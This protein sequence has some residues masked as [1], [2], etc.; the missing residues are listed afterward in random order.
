VRKTIAYLGLV[1]LLF[2]GLC[3]AVADAAKDKDTKKE[4]AS[5][6][7]KAYGKT[8]D[9]VAVEEY[10]LTNGSGARAKI[11]TYGALLTELDVPDRDG[12]L[13]DVVLGFDNLKDYLAGHPYFG[14]TVG[15][16]G[17]RIAGAE[18]TLG[19]KKYKLAA[20]NGRHSLHGGQKGFDKVVWKA[21]P[22]SAADGASV[23]FT[24][25]SK[26]GEEGY[27][28]N[29]NVTVIY[30]L[31]NDNALR[32]DYEAK[33]DKATP[34]NLTNHSYFNLA[35]TQAGDVLDHEL[36]IAADRYTPSD[37][38]LVPTGEIKP[39]KDTPFDFTKPRRIGERID[40]LRG[41]PDKGNPGG[42]DLNYVLNSGGKELALA[43]RVSEPKTGRVME[44]WTTEPGIQ[45]YTGNFLDGKLKGR[46]GVAYK[47]HWGFCLETQHFPDAVH[48]DNF[49]SIILKPDQTYK[50]TTIY[51]F[52]TK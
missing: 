33:T 28:G 20:N 7:K 3:I 49:P 37:D 23:Q 19:G 47:K 15:R 39:V 9:G 17:N 30:T 45:L 25:L 16:V 50:Q 46:G 26:D 43:A 31:T 2:G 29:L 10:V 8:P 13:G 22:R 11:I 12:K 18:F 44:V 51:K 48:H 4:K 35:G 27:P 24:Y 41:N 32:L 38:T 40:R 14:A 6:E 5:V 52:S 34:I 36:M 1:G 21:E 42:Y